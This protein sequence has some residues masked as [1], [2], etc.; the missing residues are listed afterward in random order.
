MGGVFNYVNLHVYHYAGNNPV[1]YVDPD[2]RI[3]IDDD[4]K[5]IYADL[6]DVK[7]LDKAF[8]EWMRK[9]GDGWNVVASDKD[10]TFSMTFDKP[11]KLLAYIGEVDSNPI[12]PSGSTLK[13]GVGERLIVVFG[14]GLEGGLT[15]SAENGYGFYLSG[16]LGY[17][18]GASTTITGN[19]NV[20]P[21]TDLH[22]ETGMTAT[23]GIGLMAN[24][25]L[26]RSGSFT[27]ISG[28]GIGGGVLHTKTI[29]ARGLLKDFKSL[30]EKLFGQ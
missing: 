5:I 6:T 21:D 24:F 7:D 29:T 28:I 30:R 12:V 9:S 11:L 16:G 27:G 25:D 14:A 1:R 2:G 4:N 18:F 13:F 3:T 26:R 8:E 19:I 17:G 22:G 20:T 15:Y 23:A 10:N